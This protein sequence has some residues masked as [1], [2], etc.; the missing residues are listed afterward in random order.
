MYAFNQNMPYL[1]MNY[2]ITMPFSTMYRYPIV[3]VE[4]NV[5]TMGVW[6]RA[7]GERTEHSSSNYYLNSCIKLGPNFG[8]LMKIEN[9]KSKSY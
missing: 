8:Y 2:N 9:H 3:S 1:C 5:V 4:Q 6:E 7:E